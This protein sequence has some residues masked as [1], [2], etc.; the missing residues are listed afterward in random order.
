MKISLSGSYQPLINALELNRKKWLF[1]PYSAATLIQLPIEEKQKYFN[2][3][4]LSKNANKE[5]ELKYAGG[6]LIALSDVG[7]RDIIEGK[8]L[9]FLPYMDTQKAKAYLDFAEQKYAG[10]LAIGIEEKEETE[11]TRYECSI[12]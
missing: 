5:E 8:I 9:S 10:N 6:I 3:P 11:E 12:Q 7:C 4:V 1:T 2:L